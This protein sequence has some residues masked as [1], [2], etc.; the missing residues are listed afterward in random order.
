MCINVEG[1]TSSTTTASVMEWTTSTK[2]QRLSILVR[3]HLQQRQRSSSDSCDRAVSSSPSAAIVCPGAPSRSSLCRRRHSSQRFVGPLRCRS[4]AGE[5]CPS[6]RR[7]AQ[8]RTVGAAAVA[9]VRRCRS[10]QGRARLQH[11]MAAR[12]PTRA[13]SSHLD[14]KSEADRVPPSARRAAQQRLRLRNQKQKQT[15][16]SEY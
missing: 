1:W 4:D 15:Q 6:R 12:V 2:Q 7:S 3:R 11:A 10:S 14:E 13:A 16:Q 5:G 9:A 8:R